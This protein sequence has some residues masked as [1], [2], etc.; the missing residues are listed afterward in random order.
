[1]RRPVLRIS[2]AAGVLALAGCALP[3]SGPDPQEAVERLASGL[4]SGDLGSVDFAGDD[5]VPAEQYAAITEGV[6]D[7]TVSAGDVSEEEDTATARLTWKRPVGGETWSYDSKVTLT[8]ADTSDGE[9]WLVRWDPQVVEPSLESGEVLDETSIAPQRGDILGAGGVRLVT[10]RPVLRV[11]VDRT[12][13]SDQAARTSANELARL[14]G[15]APRAYADRVVAAGPRAF[16]EAI[17]FRRADAPDAVLDG[18]SD[19]PGARAVSDRMPLAPTKEFAA[20]ILGTVG[21]ATAELVEKSD[22]RIRAGDDVGLSGLQQRYDEQLTGTRGATV[23]AVDEEGERRTLFTAEPEAGT[24]LRTTLA[25]DTQDAA[26]EALSGVGPASALVAIRPSTGEL[27]A[28]ASGA[29]SRGYNTATFGQYAPGSTFKVVSSLALLRAGL[30]PGTTVPCPATTVVDGKTFKNYDDYPSSGLGQITLADAV[31]NSCNTAFISQRDRPGARGLGEAAAAL[32]LGVDHD[33]GF[34]TF[35]G[36]VE[37]AASETQQAAS[38]IGQGT[39]LASPMAMAAVMASVVKGA[40]VVPTLL[41]DHEVDQKVP[42]QPLTGVEARQ[43]RSMLRGV[44]ER[45]SGSLLADVPG[46]PVIAKTGT[47]EFGEQAPLPTHAW[48]V[49]GQGDLAVAVFVERGDSGSGTAGPVLE[50][51]LR[52]VR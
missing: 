4:A 1:M 18:L 28:V 34:P 3:G 16:V 32:G 19:I 2:L 37:P 13:L 26:Q 39:V 51:F 49:A 45:G 17:V 48:M 21:P 44:V 47:A 41:P 36:Q 5:D 46:P 22:G 24:P 31:A 25:V 43:L 38:M 35:F 50:D 42:A 11:G 7:A 6:G 30:T 10:E 8:R 52:A 12:G 20:E 40:A 29:G 14:V 33:T 27:V 15:I 23:A 9:A